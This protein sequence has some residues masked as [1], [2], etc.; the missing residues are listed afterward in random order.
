MDLSTLQREGYFK[1]GS[2]PGNSFGKSEKLTYADPSIKGGITYKFSGRHLLSVNTGFLSKSPSIRNLFTNIRVSNNATPDL[3][4]EKI[5][6][7]DINY[8]IRL[9]NLLGRFTTFRTLFNNGS[10]SRFFFAQGLMGDQA[11]FINETVTGISRSHFGFEWSVDYQFLPTLKLLIAGTYGKYTYTNNP[12]VL[13]ESDTNNGTLR[14]FGPTYIKGMHVP[15]SHQKAYSIGF[16]YN[17]PNYWWFQL[18]GNF[19][20]DNY[21]SM[22]SLLRTK[23]FFIDGDGIPFISEETGK[24][25]SSDEINTLLNQE[26]LDDF[27][28]LNIVGGKSWKMNNTY[29]SLFLG[30]NNVLGE[31]FRTGG[32]EQS[33]YVNYPE[34]KK[35]KNRDL[36]LF[37][38]KYWYGN[39]TT[40]FINLSVKL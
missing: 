2:Y 11:D 5:I 38:S 15:G 4:S 29:L 37:G 23:N 31:V 17:D 14:D 16:E 12:N 36:P 32:F 19:M 34:Y 40:Y 39:P 30:I 33:R 10:N 8:T 6:L 25:I 26:K 13:V 3:A 22:S 28:L 35:D 9:P 21:L 20:V 1:N 27:F 18:N 7:A 24:Q